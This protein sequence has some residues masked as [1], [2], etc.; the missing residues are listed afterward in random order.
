MYRICL[1]VGSKIPLKCYKN[2]L[3]EVHGVLFCKYTR[4]MAQLNSR[5]RHRR[6]RGQ[7]GPPYVYLTWPPHVNSALLIYAILSVLLSHSCIMSQQLDASANFFTEKSVARFL[8]SSFMSFLFA[9]HYDWFFSKWIEKVLQGS[10]V[11][12]SNLFQ[13]R[14]TSVDFPISGYWRPPDDVIMTSAEHSPTNIQ[15]T[16]IKIVR[17]QNYCCINGQWTLSPLQGHKFTVLKTY[18]GNVWKI[19]YWVEFTVDHCWKITFLHFRR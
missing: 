10:P 16:M 2:K 12:R 15:Q 5:K 8:C 3:S 7:G 17:K 1:Q 9:Y 6:S 18:F 13:H 19:S 4:R 11:G 14:R